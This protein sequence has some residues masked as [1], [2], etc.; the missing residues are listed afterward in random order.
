[1]SLG[2]VSLGTILFPLCSC[3]TS[4]GV[5]NVLAASVSLTLPLAKPPHTEFNAQTL[6][7]LRCPCGT[8]FP[9]LSYFSTSEPKVACTACIW[10]AGLST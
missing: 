3:S 6:P 1:M 8:A 5:S 2:D 10:A 7:H 4:T 9:D